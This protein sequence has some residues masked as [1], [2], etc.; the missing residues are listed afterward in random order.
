MEEPLTQ[1]RSGKDHGESDQR[2]RIDHEQEQEFELDSVPLEY[3]VACGTQ[4][5]RHAILL[6]RGS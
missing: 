1:A 5:C 3:G 2:E 6:D 4:R